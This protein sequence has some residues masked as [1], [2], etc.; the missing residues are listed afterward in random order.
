MARRGP[1][2]PLRRIPRHPT[3]H[4]TSGDAEATDD[5][6][7]GGARRD[8]TA[9]VLG[10]IREALAE[11]PTANALRLLREASAAR[12]LEEMSL[13][14]FLRHYGPLGFKREAF[15]AKFAEKLQQAHSKGPSARRAARE[16]LNDAL[17]VAR[18]WIGRQ[19][20]PVGGE[21]ALDASRAAADYHWDMEEAHGNRKP[22]DFRRRKRELR[23]QYLVSKELLDE[24]IKRGGEIERVRP[25]PRSP[26]TAEEIFGSFHTEAYEKARD[27]A[28]EA[29]LK[30]LAREKALRDEARKSLLEV[31]RY[32][33]RSRKQR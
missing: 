9:K 26:V 33:A 30:Y 21:D 22:F 16:E 24:A 7:R 2:K 27:A 29:R 31:L 19:G 28:I 14:D 15:H 25:L 12:E 32:L 4:V 17:A 6:L 18:S 13:P 23:E 1:Q 20:P 5:E 10:L 11:D 8:P 3:L